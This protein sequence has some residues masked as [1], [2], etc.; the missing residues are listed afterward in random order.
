MFQTLQIYKKK[1]GF[2]EICPNANLLYWCEF[3]KNAN[4]F[5]IIKVAKVG[6]TVPNSPSY[7]QEVHLNK[8]RCTQR[9]NQIGQLMI[10]DLLAKL[11]TDHLE[12]G[13]S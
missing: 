5:G 12:Y 13:L 1:N 3:S 4:F 10:I 7:Y 11:I 8:L 2:H 9:E 6:N